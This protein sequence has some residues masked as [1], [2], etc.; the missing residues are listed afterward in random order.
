MRLDELQPVPMNLRKLQDDPNLDMNINWVLNIDAYL[1]KYGYTRLGKG[2]Y[3]AVYRNDKQNKVLKVF[4]ND[5][6][7]KEWVQFSRANPNNVFLP[8]FRSNVI[9]FNNGVNGV[10]IEP[11]DRA[12]EDGH[13]IANIISTIVEI[14]PEVKKYRETGELTPQAV[15]LK[16]FYDQ[17]ESSF[18]YFMSNTDFIQAAEFL[19]ARRNKADI[20]AS[21]IM[22]RGQQFVITDPLAS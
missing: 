19:Y 9:E 16:Q 20:G 7:Y 8:K 22:K 2:G 13:T 17:Y 18:D 14:L 11:L 6:L 3:G 5:P 15:W 12:G 1:S 10:M 21:N 4:K